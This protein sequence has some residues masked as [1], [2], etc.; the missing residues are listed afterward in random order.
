MVTSQNKVN[1]KELYLN[2]WHKYMY[3]S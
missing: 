2:I 1:A 3:I